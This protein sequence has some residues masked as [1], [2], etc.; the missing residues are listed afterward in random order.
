MLVFGGTRVQGG[1][2]ISLGDTWLH[3]AGSTAAAAAFGN[4]CGTP[5]LALSPVSINRP[6][7]GTTPQVS[8]TGIPSSMSFVA[9][10]WSNTTA[11][12]FQ[13]PMSLSGFGMPGCDLL[14]SAEFAA[15]PMTFTGQGTASYGLSLPNWG[16]LVG[17]S[18]FLQA[19]ANAP[20]ANTANV[21]VSNGVEWV[22]GNT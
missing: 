14:Q 17:V 3:D 21:I 5:A 8:L 19:W 6:I 9:I 1:A 11:G 4:G 22:V 10:G 15:I 18:M 7:I 13:L 2:N 12:V 20:G 16:A